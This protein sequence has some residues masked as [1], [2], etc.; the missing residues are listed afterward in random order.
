[1][2]IRNGFVTNS[3]SSSFVISVK[4]SGSE[5]PLERF[6]RYMIEEFEWPDV[7]D[8]FTSLGNV[9]DIQKRMQ[10]NEFW[11]HG[12][13][14]ER[15]ENQ[16]KTLLGKRFYDLTFPRGDEDLREILWDLISVS[17]T[18]KIESTDSY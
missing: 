17:G 11:G 6:F 4:N 10:N 13:L 15:I 7:I 3:S 2:K 14:Q 1:M 8:G 5:E 16:D 9:M 18:M 12:L